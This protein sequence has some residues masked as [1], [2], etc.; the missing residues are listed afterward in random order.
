MIKYTMACQPTQRQVLHRRGHSFTDR[1]Q[2]PV[3]HSSQGGDLKRG[4]EPPILSCRWVLN[5]L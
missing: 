4:G 3:E 5:A 1:A 2:P